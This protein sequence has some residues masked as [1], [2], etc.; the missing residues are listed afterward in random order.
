[1]VV[2]DLGLRLDA[3]RVV[4]LVGHNGAGKTTTMRAL[5]GLSHASGDVRLDGAE[6]AGLT[7]AERARRGV[8]LVPD[9]GRGVFGT[10]SV[11]ENI[12]LAEVGLP[13]STRRDPDP[14][15]VRL[16]AAIAPFLDERGA[17]LAGTLSGGQRQLLALASVLRR[18]PSVLLLDEPSIGLA[19]KVVDDL[20]AGVR[21][22]ADELGVGVILV[23]QDLGA[24]LAIADSVLVMKEGRLTARYE[25]GELPPVADLWHHF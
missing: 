18:G 22:A 12:R 11:E 5:A 8:S 20:L 17:Q 25:A 2:R 4:A 10:L 9:G 1:V 6:I 3:G 15:V 24:A 7:A 13:A 19:P 14:S 23:E 21:R 16:I